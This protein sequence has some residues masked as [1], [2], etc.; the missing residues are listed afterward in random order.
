MAA[1]HKK[2]GGAL[3]CAADE[4]PYPDGRAAESKVLPPR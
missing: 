1:I 2:N 3:L 4:T